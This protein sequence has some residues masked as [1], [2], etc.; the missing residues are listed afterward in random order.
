MIVLGTAGPSGVTV[1]LLGTGDGSTGGLEVPT[2]K[3]T[4]LCVGLKFSGGF[5][6]STVDSV[7][8]FLDDDDS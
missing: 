8:V 1:M 7:T 6:G 2:I 5:G 3:A 4:A